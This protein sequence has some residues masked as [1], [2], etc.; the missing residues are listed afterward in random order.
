MLSWEDCALGSPG[1]VPVRALPLASAPSATSAARRPRQVTSACKRFF[2]TSEES[3]LALPGM[4]H[5][6]TVSSKGHLPKVSATPLRAETLLCADWQ[7]KISVITSKTDLQ[8]P[9]GRVFFFF[10]P[11]WKL[12]QDRAS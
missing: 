3:P 10:S 11:S 4:W 2:P 12:L 7:D 1:V 8:P 5:K 6:V 9:E